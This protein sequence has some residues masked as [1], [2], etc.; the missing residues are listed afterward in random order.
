MRIGVA[1]SYFRIFHPFSGSLTY[2]FPT[3]GFIP[4]IDPGSPGIID[5]DAGEMSRCN[6]SV[7]PNAL[8]GR[9]WYMTQDKAYFGMEKE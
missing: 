1:I 8:Q 7:D 3:E 2:Y 6:Q 9:T 5:C 4:D